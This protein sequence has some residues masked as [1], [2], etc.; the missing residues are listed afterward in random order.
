MTPG[1]TIVACLSPYSAERV[2]ALAGTTEI[3]VRLVPDPP[4]PEAVRAAVAGADVIIGDVRAKHRLDREALQAAASCRLIQQPAVGFDSIDVD[5]AA[6]LGIPVA[7][8]GGYNAET[9]ADWV[10]MAA[11]NLLR[12]GSR[13][14]E[15]MHAGRYDRDF[16]RSRELSAMTVGIIGM[17]NIGKAV[18]RRLSGFGSTMI[19][20][21]PVATEQVPGVQ[22]VSLETLLQQADIITIH[23]PLTDATRHLINA[24][25]LQQMQPEA[26]IINASRGPLVD[27]R[28]LVDALRSGSIGG[29]ALDVYEVEPL[30]ADSPL[31]GLDNVF[32]TPH[33]AG[34]SRESRDRLQALVSDNLQRVLLHDLPPHHVVNAGLLQQAG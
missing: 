14:D 20:Y 33:I 2:K 8:A 32:L 27:E 3:E 5:A 26:L 23:A 28:A 25:T 21:D 10:L 18:A 12:N 11:L 31:R 6:E 7:N 9:V 1:I 22:Q 4:A 30:A 34:D 13:R 17:G 19:S 24:T 15:S 16:E 29:A